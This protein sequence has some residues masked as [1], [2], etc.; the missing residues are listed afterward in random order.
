KHTGERTDNAH[1]RE[2]HEH[3]CDAPTQ[4]YGVFITVPDSCNRDYSPPDGVAARSD[5]CLSVLAFELEHEQAGQAQHKHRQLKRYERR[6]LTAI[7]NNVCDQVRLVLS[8]ENTRN[9]RQ[10]T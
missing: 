6:V 1:A 9:A 8:A 10:T 4:G 7:A 3:G 2:H 5:V